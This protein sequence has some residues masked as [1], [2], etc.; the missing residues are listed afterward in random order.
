MNYKNHQITAVIF[1]MD[2]TMIDTEK[3]YQ[4]FWAEAL[5]FYGYQPTKELLLKLRSLARNLAAKLLK[6]TYGP[7]INYEMIREKRVEL[8]DHYIDI[9]GVEKKRGLDEL[10]KFLKTQEVAIGVATATGKERTEKYLKQIGILDYFDEIVCASMV[11]H[12][13]PAPDI[14]IEAAKRLKKQ[15]KECIAV[16]D[17]PNGVT[18]ALSAGYQVIM[19]PEHKGDY[20]LKTDACYISN[21]LDEI[22]QLLQ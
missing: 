2:G 8:M 14:Y 22:V 21:S 13:K 10:L 7:N 20:C 6:E 1:D 11:A 5:L 3:L 4:I 16:E 17:S 15:P 12:G 9:H 18:S 19:V